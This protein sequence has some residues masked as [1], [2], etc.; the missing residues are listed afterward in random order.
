MRIK[1]I[2][3]GSNKWER[4]IRRW[5]VSFLIGED[6][7]F[8]TFGDPHVFLDNMHK[9]SVDPFK[10]KHVVLSHDDWDHV[11]GLW[12]MLNNRKDITVYICPGFNAQIKERIRSFGAR[13]IEMSGPML[14]KDNVYSTGELYGESKGRKI[15]E[16]SLVIKTSEGLA[17]ICGCAHPGVEKIISAV[18]KQFNENIYMLAGG[19]HLKD[20]SKEEIA[21]DLMFLRRSGVRKVAPMH[22]TGSPAAEA[23]RVLFRKGFIKIRE[24]DSLEL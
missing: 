11:S 23:M 7:L 18:K 12:Y 10:I 1:V 20:S 6:M 21:K 16:Q 15:Y 14:I 8:D 13:V 2:A 19:L 4:F 5:G 3:T 24:G 9:F 17:V 22:C